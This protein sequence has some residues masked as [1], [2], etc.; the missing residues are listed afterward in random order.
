MKPFD[1]KDYKRDI[2]VLNLTKGNILMIFPMGATVND[3]T[4]VLE[5]N[6][7]DG[8][9]LIKIADMTD[10]DK[11]KTALKFIISEWLKLVEK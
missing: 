11:Q 9:R 6:Y 4:G 10:L 8:R 3:T 7:T 2:V 1:L 5:G